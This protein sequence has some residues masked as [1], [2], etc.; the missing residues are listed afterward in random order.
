[1]TVCHECE[2]SHRDHVVKII[3]IRSK[4]ALIDT[5]SLKNK[6]LDLAIR[7]KLTRQLPDD[8]TAEELYEKIQEEKQALVEAGKI[9]KEKPLKEIEEGEVPFEIPGN[10][11]W[12]R[13]SE[14]CQQITDGAHKTP[15]YQKKRRSFFISKKYI[16]RFFGFI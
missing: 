16:S 10:W 7:G 6:I 15:K 5:Q 2:E 1:M 3:T 13:L 9:K 8:G 4:T 11:K 12:V 14:I